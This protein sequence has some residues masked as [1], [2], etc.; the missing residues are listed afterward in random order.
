MPSEEERLQAQHKS[1]RI[2]SPA[3]GRDNGDRSTNLYKV[4]G[5]E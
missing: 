3:Q 4:K 5:R 2:F 1:E